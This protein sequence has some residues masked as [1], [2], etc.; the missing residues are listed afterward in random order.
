MGMTSVA[1]QVP[2][3]LSRY[4]EVPSVVGNV[5]TCTE[6]ELKMADLTLLLSELVGAYS[7]MADVTYSLH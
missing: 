5:F 4:G 2:L 1:G 7:K 3:L 6:F